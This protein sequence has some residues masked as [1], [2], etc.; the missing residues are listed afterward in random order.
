MNCSPLF[1]GYEFVNGQ[2]IAHDFLSV[3]GKVPYITDTN[4]STGNRTYT[5][6]PQVSKN[7][8]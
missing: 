1:V 3:K 2:K 4:E 8:C 5:V 7:I 6:E